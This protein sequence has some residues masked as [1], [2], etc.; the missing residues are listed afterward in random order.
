M[1]NNILIWGTVIVYAISYNILPQRGTFISY[2]QYLAVM[3]S[4]F[5]INLSQ[6]FYSLYYYDVNVPFARSSEIRNI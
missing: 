3:R 1:T 4:K 6:S 2:V 5:I